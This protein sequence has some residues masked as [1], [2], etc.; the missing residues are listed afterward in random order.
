M[1]VRAL[2]ETGTQVPEFIPGGQFLPYFGLDQW[3]ARYE[4]AESLP[5]ES[6]GVSPLLPLPLSLAAF[7]SALKY[8][9]AGMVGALHLFSLPSPT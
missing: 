4:G 8:I 9:V 5:K 6:Q 7:L 3:R 2:P 1:L